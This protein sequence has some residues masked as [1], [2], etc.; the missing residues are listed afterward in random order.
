MRENKAIGT[1]W[2]K[3]DNR[4]TFEVDAYNEAQKNIVEVEAGR[5]FANNQF[6]KDFFEA[7]IIDDIDYLIIAV[8]KPL[9]NS[10]CQRRISSAF[11]NRWYRYSDQHLEVQGV[12]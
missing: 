6:L 7:I 11:V 8:R 5:A 1:L 2:R 4:K 10:L 3:R 12:Q 9:L